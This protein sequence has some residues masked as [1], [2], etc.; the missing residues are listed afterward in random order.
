MK[1]PYC[2]GESRV[3]ESR[4]V[5]DS[6]IIRRRRE[7]LECGR[8]FSTSEKIE[9][10]PLIVIKKDGRREGFDRNKILGGM[11]KACEKRS[12]PLDAMERT[13]EE[14]ERELRNTGEKEVSSVTIGEKVMDRLR[15]LDGVAYVRFASVY[16]EFKDINEFREQLEKLLRSNHG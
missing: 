2:V 14:I 11:L 16:R 15:T 1:C 8:R 13:V 9:E 5:E 6:N 4:H 12:V 3:L 10:Q 7:C